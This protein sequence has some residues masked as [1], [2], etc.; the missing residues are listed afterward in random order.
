MVVNVC[1]RV[2]VVVVDRQ[3]V[4]VTWP[5]GRRLSVLCTVPTG[6]FG[7]RILRCPVS[8]HVITDYVAVTMD[9]L[10]LK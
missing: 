7:I 2:S 3:Y 10:D 4:G 9:S 6:Y 5:G 8:L 1:Q